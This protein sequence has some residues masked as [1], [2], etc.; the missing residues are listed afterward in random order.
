MEI[1]NRRYPNLLSW[2]CEKDV[3]AHWTIPK[4][5]MPH[6]EKLPAPN[7]DGRGGIRP[8]CAVAGS[9]PASGEE[10][11]MFASLLPFFPKNFYLPAFPASPKYQIP[12]GNLTW[13]AGKWTT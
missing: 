2:S 4:I 3:A 7:P 9:D 1:P 5:F 10:L 12:S 13:L 8:D 6:V 11:P